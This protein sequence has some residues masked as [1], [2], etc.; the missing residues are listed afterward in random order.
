MKIG[1]DV[2]NTLWLTAERV[3]GVQKRIVIK[4]N[5]RLERDVKAFAVIGI[6]AKPAPRIKTEAPLTS[7]E[8]LMGPL[9]LESDANPRLDIA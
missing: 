3:G 5:E 4:L 6:P 2:A 7:P 1:L 9:Y 8:S